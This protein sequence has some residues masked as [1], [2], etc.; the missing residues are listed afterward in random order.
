MAGRRKG[1]HRIAAGSAV[2]APWQQVGPPVGAVLKAA[3]APLQRDGAGEIGWIQ[4]DPGIQAV[5]N[6]DAKCGGG[7]FEVMLVQAVEQVG[8][9]GEAAGDRRRVAADPGPTVVGGVLGRTRRQ[10]VIDPRCID[11]G[12]GAVVLCALVAGQCIVAAHG[13]AEGEAAECR[14]DAAGPVV[15]HGAGVGA[16]NIAVDAVAAI[17]G[18]ELHAGQRGTAVVDVA[19]DGD[20]GS[21]HRR[22]RDSRVVPSGAAI[23]EGE[24]HAADGAALE[25]D[26]IGGDFKT[27]PLAGRRKGAHRVAAGSA[28]GAPWQ[29]VGTPIGTV[30]PVTIVPL[31]CD[32]GRWI[33]WVKID[34]RIQRF[35]RDDGQGF[36]GVG[37][38]MLVNACGDVGLM[39]EAAGDRRRVAADPGPTVVGGRGYGVGRQ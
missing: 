17:A 13:R 26:Q 33:G 19:A 27:Y 4:V 22:R 24:G 14:G 30:I 11:A 2:G 29:L 39:G 10:G 35:A 12:G 37:E 3:V 18:R 15:R 36:R 8:L 5:A 20:I 28:I 7:V 9:V 23:D 31:Q 6:A 32:G 16:D 25:S 21:E 34:P 38:M 1:A